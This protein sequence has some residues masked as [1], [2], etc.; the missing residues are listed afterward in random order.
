MA[1]K[2]LILDSDCSA[3]LETIQSL[4]RQA[5]VIHAAAQSTDHLAAHSRYVG[6][7]K[8]QPASKDEL[9]AWIV[10]QHQRERYDLIVPSTEVSLLAFASGKVDDDVYRRAV[11]PPTESLRHALDKERTLHLAYE[12]GLSVPAREL[13]DHNSPPP[14]QFPVVLKPT[15]SKHT[16]ADGTSRDY[17]VTI[18]RDEEQWRS[19]L[20]NDYAGIA[21]QQQTY[22]AGKGVGVELLYEHGERRWVFCHE[23]LHEMPLTGGGSSYRKSIEAAPELV[24]QADRLM[25]ALNWHGVAMVEFKMAVDGKAYLMEINP[26]LWGSLAL[27]I[28]AGVDFPSGLLALATGSALGPQP[29]YRIGYRTRNLARDSQWIKANLRADHTDPLLLTRPRVAALAEYVRPLLGSESW[30]FFDRH[31]LGVSFRNIAEVVRSNVAPIPRALASQMEKKYLYWSQKQFINGLTRIP[32]GSERSILFLCYG[33]ICRSP[34]AE[35][36]AKKHMPGFAIA[37]AGFYPK[38]GR[39]SPDFMRKAAQEFGVDLRSHRSQR[40]DEA[41]VGRHDLIIVMDRRNYRLLKQEFP[42]AVDKTL[43][44]GMLDSPSR[45]EIADP[46]ELPYEKALEVCEQIRVSV[47]Q[48]RHKLKVGNT[49][50]AAAEV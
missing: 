34:F 49:T 20:K 21:V 45:L 1:F 22:V 9:I 26:R 5:A 31:D 37:S 17:R 46:Y 41:M 3:G 4:G 23:R 47:E 25:Q 6:Q 35:A 32:A 33:N 14:K 44:L 48:L 2:V 27:G 11:L 38:D 18:A 24:A 36:L 13:V 10:E 42:R 7:L 19:A 29:K 12:L 28:D 30:D 43:F 50:R 16:M 40:V 39:S 8:Q 15:Q